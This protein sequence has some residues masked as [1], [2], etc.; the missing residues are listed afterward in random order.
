M[1]N[2]YEIL[3]VN[4]TAS[5]E[6]IQKVYK[7]LAKKYHPDLQ[8]ES[9]SK[10]YE[11]KFKEIAEAYEI[12]SD[13]AKRENYDE[14]LSIFEESQKGPTVDLS[15]FKDLRDYCVQLENELATL[16]NTSYHAKG[17]NTRYT[18][19]SE[20]LNNQSSDSNNVQ[21]NAYKDAMDKA[22]YDS[23]INN[24]RNLGYKIRYKKTFKQII[25]NIVALILTAIIISILGFIVWS[26]PSLKNYLL[27]LFTI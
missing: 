4:K 15:D 24:L 2:Y 25:K 13:N 19:Y 17:N 3:E 7:F 26:I 18:S 5:K 10:N 6:V 20:P 22:Y 1:K 14:Q 11:E 16:K 21:S 8:E 12:L 9:N 27:S 23:Y